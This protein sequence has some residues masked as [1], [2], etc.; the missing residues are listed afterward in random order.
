VEARIVASGAGDDEV[1]EA[2]SF[3]NP[4]YFAAG[5]TLFGTEVQGAYEF[6]EQVYNGRFMHV[7]GF[8]ACIECHD[9]HE[10]KVKVKAC[11]TCHGIQS[12]EELHDIRMTNV[13]YDGDD[14]TST[15]IAVEVMNVNDA[16]YAAIQA[17]AAEVIGVPIAFESHSYP[18]WF[19][20]TN[21][22]GVAGPDEANYGNQYNAWT[23]RLLRAAYNYT[24]TLKDPGSFAH[25]GLYMLQVLYDTLGDIGGDVTGMTR[26]EVT[27]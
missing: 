14:D 20:D 3:S 5:A 10:L 8:Q 11:G 6:A 13:D 1:S 22:N 23:P 19:L 25:N 16:I 18:Y 17:Y 24:W 9:T 15:G 12:E 21:G 27:Q 2:L 7:P 4:H 26:P